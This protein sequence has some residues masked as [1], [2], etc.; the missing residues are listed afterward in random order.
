[1]YGQNWGT[2][3]DTINYTTTGALGDWFDS[4][5]GL[6]ADGIDNEMSFSHLDRNINFEPTTEQLHVDGNKGLIYAHLAE[7]LGRRTRSFT[8]RAARATC[9][10][11]ASRSKGRELNAGAPPGT[12]PQEDVD[13]IVTASGPD[14]AIYEFEVKR[15]AQTFNGGMRIDVTQP[16][17]QGVQ[18]ARARAPAAHP[19]QGL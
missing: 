15:D 16:N 5:A 10:S 3:Y 18:P 7:I 1:M 17:V 2:V 12:S 11:G 19:V 14:Q 6:N 9:R 13:E 8:S 4:R